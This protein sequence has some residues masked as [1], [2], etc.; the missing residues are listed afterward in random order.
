MSKLI[1]YFV[2]CGL[3]Y[4]SG[5][6]SDKYAE[7]N[8]HV[9]PLERSYKGKVLAHYPNNV[10]SNPFDESAVCMFS[11][12]A[13][14]K[15]RTQK[16]SVTQ[17]PNFHSYVIT[18]EDGKRYYG[19][20]L[21][22]YEEV[23]NRDI[24]EAMH[25][26]QAM[27]ITEL[28]SGLKEHTM[29]TPQSKVPQSKSLP[30]YFKLSHNPS[31]AALTYYDICKDKLYVSKSIGIISQCGYVYAMRVFLENL[32]RCV[33]KHSNMTNSLSLESYVFN[34]LYEVQLP[35]PGKS[36]L[37]H[38]PPADPHLPLSNVII[39]NTLPPYELPHHDY[40]LRLM[41]LWLGVD[42]IVQ[43]FTCLLLEYQVLLRS[44]D[45]QKLMVVAES[46]M[47]LLFPFNWPHVYVPIMPAS[48]HHFLDAPVP[49]L[50]GLY[51]TSENIKVASEAN[52]CYVDIDKCK[53]QLP[54]EMAAFPHLEPFTAEIL[55]VLDKYSVHI[56]NTEY[57][58]NTQDIISRSSTLPSRPHNLRKL[59]IHDTLETERPPSPPGSARSEAL[60]RIADIVR[61]TGVTLEPKAN[62][63]S[64][65]YS[66]DLKFNNAIREI[67][68]NRFVHIF[69]S[70]ENFVIFPNQD[71]EDW[72]NNRDSMQNFDKASFL[73][74]Q[75]EQDRMFLWR[76]LESQMFATL[77]DNKIL[78]IWGEC[79]SNLLIFDNRIKLL[80][81]RYDR[82]NHM[83]SL[84]YEPCISVHDTQKL[85]DRRLA[86]PDF[87]SPLPREIMNC[88]VINGRQ[89][90]I[91]D[92]DIL[93]KTPVLN[94]GSIPRAST[95]KTG[96]SF[97][98]PP[99]GPNER[100]SKSSN[101]QDMSPAVIA[102]KNWS[103]VDK[104]LKDCKV[105]TKR[106]LLAKL[107]SEGVTLSSSNVTDSFGAIEETTLITSL[108]DFL[109]RVWSH[110]LQKKR[111]KSALWSHLLAYQEKYQY[112]PK[113][114]NGEFELT[115]NLENWTGQFEDSKLRSE[116]PELPSSILFDIGNI[117]SMTDVKTAIGMARVWVRLALE[118][119][120]LSK[121]LRTLLSDQT[122]LRAL[123][124]RQAFVRS[125]EE[126]EQFL[127]HLLSLNAVD[128]FCFTCT[129]VT[130]VIPYRIVIV[131][132]K[133]GATSSANVW[134]VLSGTL[135][136]TTRIVIP[137]ATLNFKIKHKNLGVLTT[138]RIGHD[139]SGL[140]AKWMIDYIIVRNDISGHTYKFPCGRW[141]GRGVDDGSTER[142]LV[143]SLMSKKEEL[144]DIT[145][146]SS[147][148]S[149][150]RSTPRSRS[151]AIAP[152][153]EMK[154]SQIQHMLGDC[155]N[156]IIKWHHRR[157]S[158]R[159]TTL[160]ALICSDN[161]LVSCLEKVFLLGFKSA[162]LFMGKHYLWDYFVRVKE[163]FELELLQEVSGNRTHSLEKN[164]QE[165]VAVWRCY[166]HLIEE[167]NQT[168][169]TLGKD[170]KFQ[171]FICLSVR[172]H[173]LH[174]MLIPM[175]KCKVTSEMYEENSF[176]RKKGLLT[177]LW[178][179]LLPLD[180]LDVVLE[181]TVSDGIS[182]PLSHI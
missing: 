148:G 41:F 97:S 4:N 9:S 144:E 111:N 84:C 11:L 115:T 27:Y 80:K 158:E 142:L 176:L 23:Q 170:G 107:G 56:P 119:K 93:N 125:E 139:N 73:S 155:V 150:G 138:F 79:D 160:T 177:F 47:S 3:D 113:K 134:M 178:Q 38:L 157:T 26:L 43:L 74:D 6:E 129:Y 104:L 78:S 105:K 8:L 91:L 116:L 161:G 53:V 103:F 64:D 21:I 49:Y 95:F 106:M 68:L 88:R 36:L 60:Q 169:K 120:Q 101:S 55:S 85:I 166:C 102:H 175:S 89:F 130:T 154:S 137:K 152:R 87:E 13:G 180:D 67:F 10:S 92:K 24:R 2:I 165:T 132:N 173:L 83:R 128:Y 114:D 121:H 112:I 86:C 110:G 167:I 22:F 66:E 19:F 172:E 51:A 72:F 108:C 131:P 29:Q 123:Y 32:Y 100:H 76:F 39:Q 147:T 146:K 63:P 109:E 163:Q 35:A 15:F 153:T 7:D 99:E 18:R 82:E 81:N 98:K 133:K 28:S 58:R 122:L 141:L 20:S 159:H 1:D 96:L 124:K 77:I 16:H 136:E 59:S 44:T 71:K 179:I 34:L 127:Y 90:P 162:R 174:R 40:P 33:P 61:R 57:T 168:S 25:T 14:L 140:Y 135:S 31:G 156:K 48:L 164:H 69:Q 70:Y 151:P 75:P 94:K 50:M 181:K 182:S 30:R 54:E 145:V 42:I 126:R 149:L 171:Q 62:H 45:P 5:L 52:L 118:K 37:V 17:A 65:S 143:G 46:V 117:Q 12:P